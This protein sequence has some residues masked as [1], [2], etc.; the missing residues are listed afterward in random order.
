MKQIPSYP[1]INLKKKKNLAIMT[2]SE[3]KEKEKYLLYLIKNNR[4]ISL[5]KT[6][7]DFNC[8]KRTIRRMIASLRDEGHYI[9]YCKIKCNY[10]LERRLDGQNLSV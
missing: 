6:A 2:Y 4:F 10:F 7:I 1:K 8:S 3:R 9:C 5:E